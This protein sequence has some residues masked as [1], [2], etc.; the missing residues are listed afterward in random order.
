MKPLSQHFVK[1]GGKLMDWH[2][3]DMHQLHRDLAYGRNTL[4]HIGLNHDCSY[5]LL[6]SQMGNKK[7]EKA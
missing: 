5:R 6:L 3:A 7:W 2:N 4:L 1:Y